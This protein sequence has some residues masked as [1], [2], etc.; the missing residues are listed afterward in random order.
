MSGKYLNFGMDG[1]TICNYWI[2]LWMTKKWKQ[3][4]FQSMLLFELMFRYVLYYLTDTLIPYSEQ[5]GWL[6]L[7]APSSHQKHETHNLIDKKLRFF[8]LLYHIYRYRIYESPNICLVVPARRSSTICRVYFWLCRCW[9][10]R[11]YN[12]WRISENHFDNLPR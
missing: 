1:D 5:P 8:C 3:P 11:Y 6:R 4:D 7:G 12:I 9:L 10:F 2:R